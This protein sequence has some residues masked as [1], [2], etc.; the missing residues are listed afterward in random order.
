MPKTSRW[1]AMALC[2]ATLSVHAAPDDVLIVSFIHP[3]RFTDARIARLEGPDTNYIEFQ[4][5]LT[6]HIAGLA[7]RRLKPG[8][9]LE[10]QV[11]DADI[12][13]PGLYFR[14]V[15]FLRWPRIN[16]H[17]MLRRGDQVLADRDEV[18]SDMSYLSRPNRYPSVDP[19]RYEKAML[20]RWF[21][22][23]VGQQN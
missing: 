11:L 2:A 19:L 13:S 6:V 23:R 16:V 18:I 3:E 1:A 17:Y 10:I 8:E 7:A 15:R 21:D 14:Y 20:D 22:K 9:Q 12:S 4:R 5:L